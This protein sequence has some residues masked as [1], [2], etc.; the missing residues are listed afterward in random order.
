MSSGR[1]GVGAAFSSLRIPDYR[2]LWWAGTLSFM[3]VQMQ[4]LLRGV[5]AWDLT[6]RE[7]ALG[8]VYL[9]FGIAMLIATPLGGVAA[10]RLP[11]RRILLASQ[12]ALL[13]AAAGMGFVVVTDRVQF[14][15]LLLAAVTQGTA[16]GFFGPTR[17]AFTAELV[18]REQLG[19]AI[20]LSM[21]SLNGTRVFAPSIAGALAGIAIIGIGGTYLI[22]AVISLGAF[23]QL[24]RCPSGENLKVTTKARPL[25]EIV[26]GV[27][28]VM[29]RQHLRRLI[30][31]SFAII[32]F[33]FN[34]V[35]FIPALV[36]GTYDLTD[37]WVGLMMSA[38]S[39]GAVLVAVPLAT[40]ADGPG[41]W[42]LMVFSGAVFGGGVI[43]LGISSQFFV[44]FAVV[45][46][47]GA[48]T[49]GYQS[50]S[51]TLALNMADESHH[52]RVQSLMMLSFA[53][54]GIAAAP[55][56][57]LAEWIGLRPAIM[58]M[59]LAAL[60]AVAVY[61]LMERGS[62]DEI[63]RGPMPLPVESPSLGLRK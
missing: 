63:G 10:D 12:A 13:A 8:L 29:A 54:F 42:R 21:L 38:S 32:M 51:N 18:G 35:A 17:M 44:A 20:T 16:F 2:L 15:M 56:G 50:L 36:K 24:L 39:I 48:G 57:L 23:I 25:A 61:A 5:L 27:K 33:G 58:L 60:S 62:Q 37:G 4:F 3:S 26:D 47:V 34:Y 53:G 1:F 9:A 43:A 49:T 31:S 6:E 41:V 46:V 7:G 40:R 30:I 28:Y 19:N 45:A 59:G 22:S 55:L 14:W 11:K 52:G